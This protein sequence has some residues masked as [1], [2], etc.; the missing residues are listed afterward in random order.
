MRTSASTRRDTETATDDVEN[1]PAADS[2]EVAEADLGLTAGQLAGLLADPDRR[3]IVAALVLGAGDLS[4]VRRLAGLDARR[5]VTALSR[6]LDGG[7]VE[8]ADDGA[9]LLLESAFGMAARAAAPRPALD[10]HA[11]EPPDRARV[12]RAHV[13]GRRLLSFPSTYAKRLIV[14]DL[15]VQDFEPNTPYT[16]RQVNAILVG[17]HADTPALRRYLVDVGYLDRDHGDYW[18]CGGP[19]DI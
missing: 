17:W 18:R 3:A 11:D 6:L 2:D 19:V 15:I 7:L 10:E 9:L 14:L 4:D 8:A 5:A 1:G 13:K 16:E 12:L